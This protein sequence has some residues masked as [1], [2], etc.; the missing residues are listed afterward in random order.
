MT[1]TTAQYSDLLRKLAGNQTG[2]GDA[3]RAAGVDPNTAA[4]SEDVI[5]L[6][7]ERDPNRGARNIG[8][9]AGL[10]AMMG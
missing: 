1:S 5:R 9:I 6:L 2:F 7:S 10:V 4:Y 8:R 3:L